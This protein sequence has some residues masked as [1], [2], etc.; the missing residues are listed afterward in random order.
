MLELQHSVRGFEID[1]SAKMRLGIVKEHD[2]APVGIANVPRCRHC[3]ILN[4]A[5]MAIVS[6]APNSQPSFFPSLCPG[7]LLREMAGDDLTAVITEGKRPGRLL[8]AHI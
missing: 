8:A 6:W 5:P 3:D 4:F 1:E 2:R 7:L